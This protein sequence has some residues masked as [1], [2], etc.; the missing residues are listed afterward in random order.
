MIR[1][2]H[3]NDLKEEFTSAELILWYKNYYQRNPES[4]DIY[5]ICKDLFQMG[6]YKKAI[7]CLEYYVMRSQL[8]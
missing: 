1:S 8:I 3:Y 5:E 2:S 7:S 4:S 6:L